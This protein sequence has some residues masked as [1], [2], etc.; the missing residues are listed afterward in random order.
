VGAGVVG[1][2]V[3]GAGVVGFGVVAAGVVGA[4]VVAAGVVATG[5][6]ATGVVV[7]GV[8]DLAQPLKINT[9]NRITVARTNRSF[10]ICSFSS[11]KIYYRYYN[12][13]ISCFSWL[14]V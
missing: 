9:P 13:T 10:L 11:L 2:G 3:V 14:F 6:V 7:V 12:Y 8:V 4:G 5:V 1:A